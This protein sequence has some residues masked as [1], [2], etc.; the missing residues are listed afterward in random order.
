MGMKVPVTS[1]GY[2]PLLHGISLYFRSLMCL[3][4]CQRL[5]WRLSFCF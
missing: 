3:C 5:R 2:S 4:S 1:F